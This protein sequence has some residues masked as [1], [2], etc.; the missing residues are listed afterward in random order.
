[1]TAQDIFFTVTPVGNALE[2]VNSIKDNLQADY[3]V[4]QAPTLVKIAGHSFARFGYSSPVAELHWSVLA[5]QS[6]ATW[7]NSY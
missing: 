7:S 6:A 5:T 4:E 3:K 1:M 2:L